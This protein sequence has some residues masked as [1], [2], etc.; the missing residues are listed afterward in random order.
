MSRDV[1]SLRVV[2]LG[3][4]TTLQD[5][6][7][8]G[9]AALGV[10]RAGAVDREAH[11]LANRLV[12]NHVAAATIETGGGL[13]VEA[14]TPLVVGISSDGA[15]ITLSGG[16]R[17][18]VDPAPGEMWAYLA[19]RGGIDVEPVLGSRS[20]DTLSGTGPPMLTAGSV[21]PIGPEPH[22][23]LTTDLAPHRARDR[24]VRVWPGPQLDSFDS[25]AGLTG[26]EWVVQPETS[27]VGTRLAP[28][29]G[30]PLE[31]AN[32]SM[33][34]EGLVEGAIQVTPAGGP[35]VMLA[36]HPTTGGY[37]VIAVV[38]P[39]DLSIV[40]QSRPGTSLRFRDYGSPGP[41]SG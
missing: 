19:I 26:T 17:L 12:A 4:A 10:P 33:A 18:R 22:T 7:R 34:S 11:D 16:E 41:S 29:H 38:E 9:H 25:L 1:S 31:G 40:A 13:V 28:A 20:H 21:L 15:R 39:D 14:V 5:R 3:W 23:D 35:I 24:R 30:S 27:R 36:N 6:G 37:P 2:T 8:P 32:P